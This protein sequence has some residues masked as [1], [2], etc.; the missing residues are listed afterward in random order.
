[1]Q[2]AQYRHGR[3]VLA[4]DAAHIHSPAGGQ[5]MNLGIQDAFALA[6]ALPQGEAAVDAWAAERHKVGQRVLFATDLLTRM[7]TARGLLARQVRPRVLRFIARHEGLV[8]R[9]EHN[10]A[11]L[12]Y[13]EV[14]A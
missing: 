4:G 14:P 5:G 6:A 12:A 13:P 9:F 3:V 2:V 7:M 1:M 10:L 8:R 11:G